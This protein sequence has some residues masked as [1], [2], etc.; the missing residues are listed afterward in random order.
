MHRIVPLLPVLALALIGAALLGTAVQ[1]DRPILLA[2]AL[3][4]VACAVLYV[5][6]GRHSPP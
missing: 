6:G 1:R 4:L 5:R 2:A 3:P